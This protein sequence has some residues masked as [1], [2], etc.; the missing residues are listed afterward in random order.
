[1]AKPVTRDR[2]LAT[3][4][5]IDEFCDRLTNNDMEVLRVAATHGLRTMAH[6]AFEK[7]VPQIMQDKARLEFNVNGVTSPE[8]GRQKI[9]R[10][11]RNMDHVNKKRDKVAAIQIAHNISGLQMGKD[12]IGGGVIELW[13]P[14]SLHLELTDDDLDLLRG[15]RLKL[16][17][18]WI[19]HATLNNLEVY[20][21][22]DGDWVE[23]TIDYIQVMSRDYDWVHFWEHLDYLKTDKSKPVTGTGGFQ[24]YVCDTSSTPKDGFR[25]H[26]EIHLV[27][28]DGKNPDTPERSMW[29]CATNGVTPYR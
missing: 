27:L 23:S 18:F 10:L 19:D 7:E 15:D 1:M 6:N 24:G 8:D 5:R 12:S 29:F 17:Q 20:K 14:S 26:H 21:G 28:G 16:L 22:V 11:F 4:A 13:E 3:H 25:K 2:I 9:D